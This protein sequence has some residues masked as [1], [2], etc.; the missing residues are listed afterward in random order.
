MSDFDD[1]GDELLELA[2]D[3]DKKRKKKGSHRPTKRRKGDPMDSQSEGEPE[4]EE[5]DATNLYPLEEKYKDE[6]D[7]NRLMAMSEFEREAILASRVEEMENLRFKLSVSA[8]LAQSK[9]DDSVAQ[10][11]KRQ[12]AVRGAT[13][14]K[15]RKLEELKARRKAKGERDK[16]KSGS[17]KRDRSSSPMDMETSDEDDDEDGQISKLEQQD[18]K[19]LRLLN[20]IPPS[21]PEEKLSLTDLEQC[22][23]T[24]DMISRNCTRTWF[25]DMLRGAWV[26][27]L[28]GD[29]VYRA[30]EVISVMTEG[31]KPYKVDDQVVTLSFELKYG[32]ATKF[33]PMDRVSNSPFLEKEFS[34]L[35]S[36]CLKDNEKLPSKVDAERRAA[37]IQKL[38]SQPMTE[39]DFNAMLENKRA[40]QPTRM[41]SSSLTLE[42]SQLNAQRTLALRRQD[43]NEVAM[44]D[45]KIK[46]LNERQGHRQNTAEADEVAKLNERNRKSNL[47]A[48]RKA[49][50]WEAE[51]RRER[52]RMLVNGANG[53]KKL[54]SAT[55]SSRP[56]TPAAGGTPLLGA[57]TDDTRSVSPMAVSKDNFESSILADVDVDL[58][59]F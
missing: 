17:P 24:R 14:E 25:H 43:Y 37:H 8:K 54:N 2:G 46:E 50:L 15:N 9:G 42:K 56:G 18:E 48:I 28:I 6:E 38:L 40:T 22:R 11:A 16:N 5:A 53:L 26:R 58:G 3:G 55:P 47:E 45:A 23:I 19:H 52:K 27:Y 34:H 36:T 29:G 7:R 49:E 57:Q 1:I 51:R 12:H 30:C 33:W 41:S 59:D 21:M 32:K 10:A 31:V 20:K 44:L 4:S 35:E 13:K 39:S